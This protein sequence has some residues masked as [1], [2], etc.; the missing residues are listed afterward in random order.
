LFQSSFFFGVGQCLLF[1]RDDDDN[2]NAPLDLLFTF[3]FAFFCKVG[4][5]KSFVDNC[6]PILPVSAWAGDN[7]IA[8]SEKMPWWKGTHVKRSVKDAQTVYVQ[9]LLDALD[10]YLDRPTRQTQK[11]LRIPVGSVEVIKGNADIIVLGRITQGTVRVGD[12]LKFIPSHTKDNPCVGVV[13]SIEQV[14]NG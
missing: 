2:D 11:P 13:S 12:V 6:V 14:C 5:P 7:L 9:T 4:W 1:N 10:K 8:K 3:A